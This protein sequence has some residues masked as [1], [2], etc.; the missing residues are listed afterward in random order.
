VGDHA[1]AAVR[2][3]AVE[4]V[5]QPAVG[6]AGRGQL[7]VAFFQDPLEVEVGLPVLLELGLERG[8][9]GRCAQAAALERLLAKQFRQPVLQVADV[10]GQLCLVPQGNQGCRAVPATAGARSRP[11]RKPG[12]CPAAITTDGSLSSSRIS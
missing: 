12:K 6:L 11:N 9:A 7:L 4:L 3:R 5:Q 1:G 10:L 8:G 2:D